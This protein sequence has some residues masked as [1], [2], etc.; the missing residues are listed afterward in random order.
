MCGASRH[1]GFAAASTTNSAFFDDLFE[2]GLPQCAGGCFTDDAFF[3]DIGQAREVISK[4][5]AFGAGWRGLQPSLRTNES[6]A[7]LMGYVPTLR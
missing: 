2:D 6:L 4:I 1:D 7:V 3:D 5:C